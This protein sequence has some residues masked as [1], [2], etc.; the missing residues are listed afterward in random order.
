MELWP[1]DFIRAR[2]E[3][4]QGVSGARGFD[5]NIELDVV[6]RYGPW[7]FS[8]GPRFQFGDTQLVS[9]YFSVTPVELAA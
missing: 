7:T 3:A 5:A 1:T 6:E 8:A 2:L 9:T 4:R